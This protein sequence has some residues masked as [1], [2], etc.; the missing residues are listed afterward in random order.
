MHAINVKGTATCPWL[1]LRELHQRIVLDV[2]TYTITH[3]KERKV[4][5]HSFLEVKP[6]NLRHPDSG[7]VARPTE[8]HNKRLVRGRYIEGRVQGLKSHDRYYLN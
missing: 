5:S 2:I 6:F 3:P 8:V 4:G 1:P 7:D